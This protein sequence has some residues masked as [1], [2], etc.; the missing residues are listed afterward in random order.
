MHFLTDENVARSVVLGLR[1]AGHEIID[2]K[3][4]GWYGKTDKE[5]V[6]YAGRKNFIIITH[7]KDFLQQIQSSIILLR[8]YNQR[9]KNTLKYL[10]LL[11]NTLVLLKRLQKKVVVILSEE[12]V[13][14]HYL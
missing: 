13:E 8:F 2:V 14:F 12:N 1:E 11:L 4:E 7:D 6:V 5:L 10:L 9:P 3:E